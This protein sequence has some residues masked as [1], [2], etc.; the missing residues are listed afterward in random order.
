MLGRERE[1]EWGV[2]FANLIQLVRVLQIFKSQKSKLAI[3]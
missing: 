3:D 1:S 2:S